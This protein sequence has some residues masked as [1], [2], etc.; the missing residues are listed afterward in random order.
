MQPRA[1][2]RNTNTSIYLNYNLILDTERKYRPGKVGLHILVSGI[3]G[4]INS[5]ALRNH[6]SSRIVGV[7]KEV[8]NK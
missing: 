1:T 6:T 4:E 2:S 8:L 7:Q 3:S 5:Q